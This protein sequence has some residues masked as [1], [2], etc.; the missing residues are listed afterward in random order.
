MRDRAAPALSDAADAV[1]SPVRRALDV[2]VPAAAQY[3]GLA[4]DLLRALRNRAGRMEAVVP[5]PPA[6][7]LRV[8]AIRVVAVTGAVL[9]VGFATYALATRTPRRRVAGS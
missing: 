6:P 9:A 4:A 2:L 1:A 3:G 5:Q 8:P 7:R